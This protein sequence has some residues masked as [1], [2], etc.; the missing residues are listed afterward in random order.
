[1]PIGPILKPLEFPKSHLNNMG[2]NNASITMKLAGPLK[3]YM[4]SSQ[5]K[6]QPSKCMRSYNSLDTVTMTL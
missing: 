6:K 5:Q 1:M 4:I 2:G 3:H